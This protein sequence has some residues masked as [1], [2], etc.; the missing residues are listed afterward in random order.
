MTDPIPP[1]EPTFGDHEPTAN[2]DGVTNSIPDY[3][4]K[5][6]EEKAALLGV[7]MAEVVDTGPDEPYEAQG[8]DTGIGAQRSEEDRLAMLARV[9]SPMELVQAAD[10]AE[11]QEANLRAGGSVEGSRPT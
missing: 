8:E 2:P 4:P 5:T 1:V 11:Q 10:M 7:E 3:F 6:Q 9:H